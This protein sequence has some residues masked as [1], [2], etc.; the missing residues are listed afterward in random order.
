MTTQINITIE[1][2]KTYRVSKKTGSTF[3]KAVCIDIED[4]TYTFKTAKNE[5]IIIDN[6][7][8]WNIR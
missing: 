4:N 2:G 7:N 6:F 3:K 5:I 8:R 1:L